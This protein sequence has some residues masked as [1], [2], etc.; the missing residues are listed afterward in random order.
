MT[1][2]LIRV[3]PEGATMTNRAGGGGSTE[4][5]AA[6]VKLRSSKLQLPFTLQPSLT[7]T[8]LV[9]LKGARQMA[10]WLSSVIGNKHRSVKGGKIVLLASAR[11]DLCRGNII[12]SG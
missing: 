4:L 10:L 12:Y 8:D 1:K 11:L 9:I 2:G 5:E 7:P 6:P 3:H